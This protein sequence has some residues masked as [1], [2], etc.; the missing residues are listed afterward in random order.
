M[1]MLVDFVHY[2]GCSRVYRKKV[3]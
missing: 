2:K 1:S 3:I